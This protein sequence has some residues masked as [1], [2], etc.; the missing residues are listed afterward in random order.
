MKSVTND[1]SFLRGQ[2]RIVQKNLSN[3]I[4]VRLDM[5][6]WIAV[7]LRMNNF[8]VITREMLEEK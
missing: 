5:K 7:C 1:I 6:V 2:D 8:S 3:K 4:T